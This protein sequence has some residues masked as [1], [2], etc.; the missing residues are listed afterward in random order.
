M[1][2]RTVA[3]VLTTMVVSA[4]LAGCSGA[5]SDSDMKE[6]LVASFRPI[7][8]DD[9]A[10]TSFSADGCTAKDEGYACAV[11]GELEYTLTFG[12]STTKKQRVQGTYV[13]A[14]G[15]KGWRVVGR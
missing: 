2:M 1:Q 12:R 6:A 3:Y 4:S 9:L 5:P 7:V 14:E 10:F 15:D 11:E 8:G 13:F